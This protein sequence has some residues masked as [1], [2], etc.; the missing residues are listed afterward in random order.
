MSSPAAASA[1]ASISEL[2][3]LVAENLDRDTALF[4]QLCRVNRRFNAIFSPFLYRACDIRTTGRMSGPRTCSHLAHTKSFSLRLPD[5]SGDFNLDDVASAPEL[6]RKMPALETF[7]WAGQPLPHDA[8]QALKSCQ[9]LKS[10]HITYPEEIEGDYF[11]LAECDWDVN[12]QGWKPGIDKYCSKKSLEYSRLFYAQDLS[13]LAGLESL[14]LEHIYGNMHLWERHLVQILRN[15]PDLRKLGLSVARQAI[16]RCGGN[17]SWEMWGFLDRL[18]DAYSLSPGGSAP[19]TSLQLR[20]LGAG[21]GVYVTEATSIDKL[22]NLSLLEEVELDVGNIWNGRGVEH[23][24]FEVEET[25]VV[26][27]ELLLS[28]DACPNM[29][30]IRLSHMG[31]RAFDNLKNLHR[32]NQDFLRRLVV[33]VDNNNWSE[34]WLKEWIDLTFPGT[35][36]TGWVWKGKSL[37]LYP[38]DTPSEDW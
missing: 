38:M 1:F 18:C 10:V 6:I 2:L 17:G 37:I 24:V 35:T 12:E 5:N 25:Y 32:I 3:L 21:T 33:E 13:T 27:Y 28:P 20:S 16:V 15:C 19:T 7:E 11:E 9:N 26:N 34:H 4:A 36:P 8:P 23:Y 14:V 29:R 30:R 22:T 31:R